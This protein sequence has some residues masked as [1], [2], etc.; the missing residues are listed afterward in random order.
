VKAKAKMFGFWQDQTL[1]TRRMQSDSVQPILVSYFLSFLCRFT[2]AR[3]LH[4][5]HIHYF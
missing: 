5:N 1:C 3:L 2:S 4:S